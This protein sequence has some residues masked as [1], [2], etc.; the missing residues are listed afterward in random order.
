MHARLRRAVRIF[1]HESVAVL[2]FVN[3]P[4]CYGGAQDARLRDTS[5]LSVA[6]VEGD[7]AVNNIR[8]P[9]A[10]DPAVR[11][12]DVADRPVHGAVITF[13]VPATGAGG[14]FIDGARTA[15]VRTGED[16]MATAKGWKPNRVA[17]AFEIRVLASADGE[18]AHAVVHMTNVDPNGSSGSKRKLILL[19]VAAGAAA[20]GVLAATS[21]GGS[22]TQT[23]TPPSVVV[24][25]APTV[26]APK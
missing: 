17:G 10:L 8:T 22:S 18:V 20:A 12:T 15:T 16:G 5:G 14:F 9:R 19:A 23:T 21:R 1:I 24:P 11:V 7:G 3:V 26:G 25:G 2:L 13:T 4:L 6:V